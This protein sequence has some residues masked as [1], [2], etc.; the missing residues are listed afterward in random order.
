MKLIDPRV[1]EYLDQLVPPR[2]ALT[3]AMEE[4]AARTRFP[5]IGPASGHLC[6]LLTRLT[7]ARRIFELGSGYGYSTGWFARGVKE[8]GGGVVHH[9]VW[10]QE[11]SRK[12]REYLDAVGLA[13]QVEF[14][15]GEAVAALRA[16]PGDFDV[17]FNDIDK[18]GYPEAL[19]VIAEKLRP[20]G[21]LITDN[22]LWSGQIFDPENRTPATEG[23]RTF[24][25]M[26]TEDP[27]WVSSVLPIRDGVLIARRS[28]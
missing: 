16:S 28:S 25:R 3:T 20:G 8:N 22:L 23:I 1:A 18:Q 5:I 4:E 2:D 15:V 7:A 13:D 24:T 14:Q 10:D 9:V 17:I 21:L 27:G 19:G 6:Y 12:A 26:I 11:L